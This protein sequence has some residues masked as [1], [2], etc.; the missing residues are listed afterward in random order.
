MLATAKSDPNLGE[1][2]EKVATSFTQYNVAKQLVNDLCAS[3]KNALQDHSDIN[4]S[5]AEAA[6]KLL[7]I[8]D[9][10]QEN[11]HLLDPHLQSLLEPIVD[12]LKW[13]FLRYLQDESQELLEAIQSVSRSVYG[14]SKVR[15]YKTVTRFFTHEPSDLE[16]L[17]QFLEKLSTVPTATRFWETRYIFCLWLSL[18]ALI[19]FDLTRLE[20]DAG[21]PL[22]GT[23]I[24]LLDKYLAYPSKESDA[25]AVAIARLLTRKD[26][27]KELSSYLGSMPRKLEQCFD[28]GFYVN[29]ALSSLCH[30][31]KFGLRDRLLSTLDDTVLLCEFYNHPKAQSNS[32]LRKM[33]IKL[34]Q[35]VAQCYLKQKVAKWRYQFQRQSTFDGLASRRKLPEGDDLSDDDDDCTEVPE[36]LEPLIELLLQGLQDRD[37]IVRWS[38]AKGIGRVCFRLPKDF[39]QEVIQS[40]IALFEENCLFPDG[41]AAFALSTKIDLSGTSHATWHGACLATAELGRRGLL[42][43]ERLG[44]VMQWIIRALTFEQPRLSYAIGSHVRDAASYVAWSFARA[45]APEIMKPYVNVLAPTLVMSACFDRE[46]NVRRACAASFQENVGRQGIF[47]NGIAIVTTADYFSVGNRTNAYLKVAC[48]IAQFEEYRPHIFERLVECAQSWDISI[49][50]LAAQALGKV[51]L[52]D[53]KFARE[54]VLSQLQSFLQHKSPNYDAWHGSLLALAEVCSALKLQAPELDHALEA[55]RTWSPSSWTGFGSEVLREGATR[56]FS[57]LLRL[58]YQLSEE[59]LECVVNVFDCSLDKGPIPAIS[60]TLEGLLGVSDRALAN[61]V[62]WNKCVDGWVSKLKFGSSYEPTLIRNHPLVLGAIYPTARH[63]SIL[64]D[65]CL[66]LNSTS[67]DPQS[68]QNAIIALHMLLSR[69]H[70]NR[71]PLASEALKNCQLEASGL[72]STLANRLGDTLNLDFKNCWEI[73]QTCIKD[74]TVDA[75][76]DIGSI[77]REAAMLFGSSLLAVGSESFASELV[78]D[79]LGQLLQQAAEKIDRV[80]RTSGRCIA[81][82]LCEGQLS[83]SIDSF[84]RLA[85]LR[86]DSIEW[87][88]PSSV[89]PSIV[90]LLT[91]ARYRKQLLTGLVVS[92]GGLSES[93]VSCSSSVVLD[94]ITKLEDEGDTVLLDE[95]ANDIVALLLEYSGNDRVV[96]P[97]MEFVVSLFDA[98]LLQSLSE[99]SEFYLSLV[100]NVRKQVFKTKAVKRLQLAIKIFSAVLF[101]NVEP[102]AFDC[103]QP[104]YKAMQHSLRYLVAYLVHPY[105]KIRRIAAEQLYLARSST[106][107]FEY[108]NDSV[109]KL[110]KVDDFLLMTD[111]ESSLESIKPVKQEIQSILLC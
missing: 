55:V 62:V 95:V 83:R 44:E 27:Q 82:L 38:A 65:A 58:D 103:E 111:W 100:V 59:T 54:R 25:A 26:T 13:G 81:F 108:F 4:A 101:L 73:V 30:I 5:N 60:D 24:N 21:T 76:G 77:I 93:L 50:R 94:F 15:G 39:A 46:V 106:D 35:R 9:E 67:K 99:T 40:V 79:F 36:Q 19:P 90:G 45:Y 74:Y 89:L 105:P 52:I 53:P 109:E 72:S 7:T 1:C 70:P 86:D 91:L 2:E 63:L 8:L 34:A 57:V 33:A 56:L 31:Y 22:V 12:A 84:A 10:Y 102:G 3:V 32:L 16:P 29:A 41:D 17:V 85:P 98:S 88:N 87:G 107:V 97:L 75:R 43:P 42:L 104:N 92:A 20:S 71:C 66:G 78:T 28:K 18:V 68:R 11:P 69:S 48:E 49:R 80:R 51:A 110:L 47:P 6:S 61:T 64:H 96:V 23:A 37:T 14:F